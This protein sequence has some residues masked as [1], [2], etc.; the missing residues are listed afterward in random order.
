MARIIAS[1]DLN[2]AD[3]RD[4]SEMLAS[5]ATRLPRAARELLQELLSAADAGDNLIAVREGQRLTTTQAA[6][7]LGI[8]RPRIAQLIARGLLHSERV[9]KHHRLDLADVLDRKRRTEALER[10]RDVLYT[11]QHPTVWTAEDHSHARS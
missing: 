8:S 11:D 3:R 9:G 10:M 1:T 7:I 4:I 5:E 2:T 6:K